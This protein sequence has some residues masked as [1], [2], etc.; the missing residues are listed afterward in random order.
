MPFTPGVATQ[1]D[2]ITIPGMAIADIISGVSAPKVAGAVW[3]DNYSLHWDATNGGWAPSDDPNGFH[4]VVR[5]DGFAASG[6]TTSHIKILPFIPIGMVGSRSTL[7]TDARSYRSSSTR[8]FPS[9]YNGTYAWSIQVEAVAS[10]V[11]TKGDSIYQVTNASSANFRRYTNVVGT[12]SVGT[13]AVDKVVND[14]TS[15]VVVP[16]LF[17]G[18]MSGSPVS[19][20]RTQVSEVSKASAEN[21]S[22]QGIPVYT[23]GVLYTTSQTAGYWLAGTTDLP[24]AA[25]GSGRGFYNSSYQVQSDVTAVINLMR[26]DYWFLTL[27][28]IAGS[29]SGHTT[30]RTGKDGGSGDLTFDSW[31]IRF[32]NYI[33]IPAAAM[34]ASTSVVTLD[35]PP[36]LFQPLVCDLTFPG[37]G[38]I[39]DYGVPAGAKVVWSTTGGTAVTGDVY[40]ESGG[41]VT[42]VPYPPFNVIDG[43]IN[44]VPISGVYQYCEHYGAGGA[45]GS[46]VMSRIG[47]GVVKFWIVQSGGAAA[48][49]YKIERLDVDQTIVG[50]NKSKRVT[51]AT[52]GAG[53]AFTNGTGVK[54]WSATSNLSGATWHKLSRY[55]LSASLD[56]VFGALF[57]YEFS[58]PAFYPYEYNVPRWH[59]NIE[60]GSGGVLT[61]YEY[62]GS[63]INPPPTLP[64]VWTGG[65]VVAVGALVGS[66]HTITITSTRS[67]LPDGA[68][69]ERYSKSTTYSFAIVH[70]NGDKWLRSNTTGTWTS[71][72]VRLAGTAKTAVTTDSWVDTNGFVTTLELPRNTSGVDINY[73]LV[74][75]AM[76][77]SATLYN[78]STVQELD[79]QRVTVTIPST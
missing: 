66:V 49:G 33:L 24:G 11:W 74:I 14:T 29:G 60:G 7:L 40:A 55:F 56:G 43:G 17:Q 12:T 10:E 75:E 50:A 42:G 6:D 41:D 5:A 3:L 51:V 73:T 20:H 59:A 13:A 22:S 78:D 2:L 15:F 61:S 18:D 30:K 70:P 68:D 37:P 58:N 47:N 38:S 44:R 34:R 72:P 77:S 26:G 65:Y 4:S 23:N 63:S 52:G 46:S 19:G 64:M 71:K 48:A 53:L 76:A 39:S 31:S 54:T 35:Q 1:S 21:W 36:P 67:S 9:T 79:V 32:Q 8:M 27:A 57:D 45:W 16:L 62:V 28:S 25:G 69:E